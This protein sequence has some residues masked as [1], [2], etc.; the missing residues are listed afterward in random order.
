MILRAEREHLV[1]LF[2]AGDDVNDSSDV[3]KATGQQGKDPHS[4]LSSDLNC[5]NSPGGF[6]FSYI[7]VLTSC[8]MYW[9]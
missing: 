9:R 1:L 5:F 8:D 7:F 3:N 6:F 2:M 4:S